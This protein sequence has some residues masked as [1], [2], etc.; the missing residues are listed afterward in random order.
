VTR[1]PMVTLNRDRMSMCL[2]Q[3]SV[4]V[5]SPRARLLAGGSW[6]AIYYSTAMWCCC[7]TWLAT[8]EA[9]SLPRRDASVRCVRRHCQGPACRRGEEELSRIDDRTGRRRRQLADREAGGHAMRP[10]KRRAGKQV[11]SPRYCQCVRACIGDVPA[12]WSLFF[13]VFF[14]EVLLVRGSVCVIMYPVHARSCRHYMSS[15]LVL[16]MHVGV[17]ADD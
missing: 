6:L 14:C 1:T 13:F 5:L 4:L 2:A 11:A 9:S 10:K 17:L 7:A 3:R 8:G 12:M 16:H 15:T